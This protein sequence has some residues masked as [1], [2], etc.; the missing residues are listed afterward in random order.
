MP[1]RC[2]VLFFVS[3]HLLHFKLQYVSIILKYPEVYSNVALM[4]S[5]WVYANK[6]WLRD[7]IPPFVLQV[8]GAWLPPWLAA[9]SAHYMVTKQNQQTMH[10]T[11]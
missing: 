9:H 2:T 4:L 8:H 1:C 6:I 11:F 10:L 5:S 7:F 3:Q